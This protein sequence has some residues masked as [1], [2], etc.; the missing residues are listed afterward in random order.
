MKQAIKKLRKKKLEIL[1]L[2]FISIIVLLLKYREAIYLKYYY[3]VF[4]VDQDAV[5]RQELKNFSSL[6][7]MELRSKCKCRQDELVYLTHQESEKTY[8]VDVGNK[9]IS[10]TEEPY[11]FLK[12]YTISSKEFQKATLTCDLY[13]SL[14]RGPNQRVISYSLYGTDLKYY[15][16]LKDLVMIVRKRYPNW[17]IRVHHDSSILHDFI[18]EMECLTYLDESLNSHRYVDIID[19]CDIEHLPYD[20]SKTYNV[21]YMHG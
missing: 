20:T 6:D 3:G 17:I 16:Y 9:R 21:S 11:K 5:I 14:R 15:K 2:S 12:Q 4:Y 7:Y 13:N 10:R 18:C 19:F 8:R 1:V